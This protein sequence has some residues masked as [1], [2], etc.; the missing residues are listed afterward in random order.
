MLGSPFGR[1]EAPGRGFY[2]H[3]GG[4]MENELLGPVVQA[5]ALGLCAAMLGIQFWVIKQ[6]F[7]LLRIITSD[8]KHI[9]RSLDG[10]ACRRGMPC[11]EGDD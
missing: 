4:I 9:Q 10:L 3:G 2:S 1:K 5:G 7:A 6:A 11:P 8:I